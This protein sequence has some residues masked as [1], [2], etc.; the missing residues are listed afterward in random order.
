MYFSALQKLLYSKEA[1]LFIGE[2]VKSGI[3]VLTYMSNLNNFTVDHISD[4]RTINLLGYNPID[5][6][7]LNYTHRLATNV[8]IWQ[9]LR[10]HSAKIYL[11]YGTYCREYGY[12]PL[13]VKCDR[14][15]EGIGLS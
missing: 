4:L 13:L 2:Q 7:S 8:R 6:S 3:V 11:L 9:K 1:A 12:L 15:L 14:L 10:T 5:K